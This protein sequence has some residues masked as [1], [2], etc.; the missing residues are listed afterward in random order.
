MSSNR[1]SE[2]SQDDGSTE[3]SVVRTRNAVE[4]YLHNLLDSSSA[5]VK[6]MQIISQNLDR[7]E[8]E[9]QHRMAKFEKRMT[10]IEFNVE[11]ITHNLQ[12]S[13]VDTDPHPG[14]RSSFLLKQLAMFNNSMAQQSSEVSLPLFRRV[15]PMFIPEK[16]RRDSKQATFSPRQED[17]GTVEDEQQYFSGPNAPKSPLPEAD[18]TEMIFSPKEDEKPEEEPVRYEQ[19]EDTTE[20]KRNSAPILEV[21][22]EKEPAPELDKPA[23][24]TKHE[25]LPQQPESPKFR[26]TQTV[27]TNTKKSYRNTSRQQSKSKRVSR[28]LS[29]REVPAPQPVLLQRRASSATDFKRF[30]DRFTKELAR[31]RWRWAFQ[32]VKHLRRQSMTRVSLE[33][34]DPAFSFGAR[35]TRLEDA[36]ANLVSEMQLLTP[37]QAMTETPGFPPDLWD[38]MK[39]VNKF[40]NKFEDLNKKIESEAKKSQQDRDLLRGQIAHFRTLAEDSDRQ[41]KQREQESKDLKDQLDLLHGNIGAIAKELQQQRNKHKEFEDLER[42]KLAIDTAR[43]MSELIEDLNHV[44]KLKPVLN[45]DLEIESLQELV[46]R[47]GV[48][49]KESQENDQGLFGTGDLLESACMHVINILHRDAMERDEIEFGEE[50]TLDRFPCK[51]GTKRMMVEKLNGT[52]DNMKEVLHHLTNQ[53]TLTLAI[54]EMRAELSLLVRRTEF[55]PLQEQLENLLQKL[56]RKLEKSDLD[57]ALENKVNKFE[58]QLSMEQLM[59]AIAEMQDRMEKHPGSTGVGAQLTEQDKAQFKKLQKSLKDHQDNFFKLKEEIGEKAASEEVTSSLNYINAQLRRMQNESV[60]KE[61]MDL[62]LR[63]KV[64]KRD[65]NRLAQAISGFSD[66]QEGDNAVCGSKLKCL[67]CDRPLR[68][69]GTAHSSILSPGLKT[70]EAPIV[71]EVNLAPVKGPGNMRTA[72]R[73]RASPGPGD[74][75]E[76]S[77]SEG[78]DEYTGMDGKVLSRYS[79]VMPMPSRVRTAAGGGAAG[80]NNMNTLKSLKDKSNQQLLNK[81][82]K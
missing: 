20:Y 11:N 22:V 24:I 19:T 18:E 6:V 71:Y 29:P 70:G 13:N 65:L 76:S 50:S 28:N 34:L 15:E 72:S 3:G 58:A 1:S 4:D 21:T 69:V 23:P 54:N 5:Q 80:N 35:I 9:L 51:D 14:T 31:R 16:L 47:L 46:G 36:M 74:R 32:Q 44:I 43:R 12:G 78:D 79:R 77:K 82:L 7:V 64:D 75:P 56:N 60:H 59:D 26:R 61:H 27:P 55:D 63:S 8:S 10:G 42:R 62:A 41:I 81:I 57:K 52:L 37:M 17:Q 67:S 38:K 40:S 2:S 45:A 30:K 66:H 73:G 33:K 48:I 39:E 68:N 53:G 25:S 49:L